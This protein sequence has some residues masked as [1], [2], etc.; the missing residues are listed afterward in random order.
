MFAVN[1][2]TM[3]QLYVLLF[4]LTLSST[5]VFSQKGLEFGPTFQGQTAWLI[6]NTDFDAGAELDLTWYYT[7]S[8]GVS[9]GYGIGER[10]G[11]RVGLATSFQGQDYTTS[12]EYLRLPSAKY[13]TRLEYMQI[14]VLYRYNGNLSIN[15]S[16][17]L[18]TVG[19]QFGMLKSASSSKLVL[20]TSNTF[21]TIS[22]VQD[23]KSSYN[24]LDI[25]AHLGL[26]LLV[27]F[28]PKFHMNALLN[29]NYTLQDIE[30]SS[31]KLPGRDITRNA[32][33]GVEVGFY[34]LL[35]G[36][37]LAIGGQAKMR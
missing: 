9:V 1:S 18:L 12:N 28:S 11:I 17:F 7:Y 15:N 34:L 4:L 32:V 20:D 27:R 8:Y 16:S 29:L 22:D 37:D 13:Q 6:N 36:P 14:P 3:K 25:S 35:G 30:S 2:Y 5:K 24:K 19:P 10:H 33:V 26:G 21:A 31:F 23:V